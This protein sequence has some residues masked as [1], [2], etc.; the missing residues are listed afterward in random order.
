MAMKMTHLLL[1]FLWVF[2]LGVMLPLHCV[3]AE[4]KLQDCLVIDFT[5]HTS[6]E[7]QLTAKPNLLFGTNI[8]FVKT[9]IDMAKFPLSSVDKFYF[10]SRTTG[11]QSEKYDNK[12]IFRFVDNENLIVTGCQNVMLYLYDTNGICI[13]KEKAKSNAVRFSLKEKPKGIYI[14]YVSGKYRVKFLKH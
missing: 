14:L 3:Y 9:D 11:I 12:I 4:N 5:D 8:L 2:V 7:F 6:L 10:T 1:R 13:S